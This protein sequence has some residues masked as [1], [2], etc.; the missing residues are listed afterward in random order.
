MAE[1]LW[2]P[3]AETLERANVV[4]LMRRHGFDDYRELVQRSIDEPE[5]FWAAAVEDLGIEFAEPW[6]QVLDDSRGPEWTT[7]FVGGKLEHRVE[8]R[9]PLGP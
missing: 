4:R 3:D 1:V 2:E 6:K 9:P 5:W 8:L 7:W